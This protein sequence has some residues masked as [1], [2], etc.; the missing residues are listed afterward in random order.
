MDLFFLDAIAEI[1]DKLLYQKMFDK[2]YK[3]KTRIIYIL[4]FTV[5]IL[6]LISLVT[7]L[8][9][10]FLKKSLLIAI[11]FLILDIILLYWLISTFKNNIV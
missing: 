9:I 4:I 7:F 1:L 11:L 3:L 10:L 2:K 6:L 5:T 8:C